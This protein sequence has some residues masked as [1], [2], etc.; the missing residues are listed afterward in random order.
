M[1][2]Q[3]LITSPFNKKEI[4]EIIKQAILDGTI[5]SEHQVLDDEK[6][7][8]LKV[9]NGEIALVEEVAQAESTEE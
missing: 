9:V 2:D 5:A 6:T 7:Y 1:P 4:V 3:K 8:V